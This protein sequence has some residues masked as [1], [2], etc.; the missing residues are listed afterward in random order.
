M[1]KD[2]QLTSTTPTTITTTTTTIQ[3]PSPYD[4]NSFYLK[5]NQQQPITTQS[6]EDP[7]KDFYSNTKSTTTT[8]KP[9]TTQLLSLAR[10]FSFDFKPFNHDKSLQFNRTQY[11]FTSSTQFPS[12][13]TT[14]AP[15]AKTTATFPTSVSPNTSS[16]PPAVNPFYFGLNY[17]K[18]KS[19]R[20]PSLFKSF[21]ITS[22]KSPY[23]FNNFE[24]SYL[25]QS[26]TTSTTVNP[27]Y[28]ITTHAPQEFQTFTTNTNPLPESRP[29]AAIDNNTS[30]LYTVQPETQLPSV[31]PS[32]T[33]KSQPTTTRNPLFD[34]YLK[35]LAS[36][37]KSPYN[38][39]NYGQF[40]KTS[41][42]NPKFAL[43]LFGANTN[44][45]TFNTTVTHQR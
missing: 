12:N 4:P 17:F 31:Q 14:T 34:L 13:V 8:Q 21:T 29:N 6:T 23:D 10:Q 19:T 24:N 3:N 45:A 2:P 7:Y 5:L 9:R 44:T 43:N 18:S 35:R 37:T 25:K 36:T 20:Y 40:S 27:S 32:S 42:V 41:T 16:H 26:H 22:T 38:F 15:S 11:D 39:E 33:Q 30:D 1:S 28:V